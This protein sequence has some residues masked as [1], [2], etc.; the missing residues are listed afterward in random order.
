MCSKCIGKTARSACRVCVTWPSVYAWEGPNKAISTTTIIKQSSLIISKLDYNLINYVNWNQG[1]CLSCS[2]S[3]SIKLDYVDFFF[4]A[5]RQNPEQTTCRKSRNEI[6]VL[7]HPWHS[8][9]HTPYYLITY[10]I[11][12]G[13]THSHLVKKGILRGI[14]P[15]IYRNTLREGLDMVEPEGRH[16]QHIPWT[17]LRNNRMSSVLT[18][19]GSSLKTFLGHIPII[20]CLY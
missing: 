17:N 4:K 1:T 19:T 20:S 6:S 15:N 2:F 13:H 14:A 16:H 18:R 11:V 9:V 10:I 3:Q 12:V 7:A 5:A 8:L